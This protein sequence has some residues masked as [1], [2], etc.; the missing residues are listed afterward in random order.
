[1]FLIVTVA[2][3]TPAFSRRDLRYRNDS[4]NRLRGGPDYIEEA[5]RLGE[6]RHVAAV[7]L[8]RG[9]AHALRHGAAP[10]R[11]APQT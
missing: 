4:L 5:L 9:C 8:I 1:M 11:D 2:S 7:E 6:H 10:A 3:D